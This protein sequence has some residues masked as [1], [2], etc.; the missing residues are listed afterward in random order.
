MND[1][2]IKTCLQRYDTNGYT[3]L[4]FLQAVS[5]SISLYTDFM[6]D[7]ADDNSSDDDAASDVDRGEV[8][9]SDTPSTSATTD[10]AVSAPVDNCD[11][12]LVAPMDPRIALVPCGHRRFCGPCAEEVHNRGLCCPMCRS[13]IQMLLRL[14]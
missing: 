11:V 7:V 12:C 9:Q 2:R 6:C 5:H 10:T 4:Q 1:K 8:Q 3:C 14:F 13:P